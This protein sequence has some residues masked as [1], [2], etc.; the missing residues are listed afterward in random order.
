M[1][2]KIGLAFGN[3]LEEGICT[4]CDKEITEEVLKEDLYIQ[5]KYCGEAHVLCKDLLTYLAEKIR[6]RN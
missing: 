2:D 3:R 4:V 6:D 1:Q 5:G